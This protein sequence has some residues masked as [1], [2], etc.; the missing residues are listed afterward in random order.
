MHNNWICKY[1]HLLYLINLFYCLFYSFVSLGHKGIKYHYADNLQNL[2][3][4]LETS[5]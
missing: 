2:L 1:S 3:Y 4:N 5:N